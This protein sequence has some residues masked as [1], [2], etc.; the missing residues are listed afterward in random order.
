ML[1]KENG[2]TLRDIERDTGI[3]KSN[4]RF[5]IHSDAMPASKNLIK[6]CEYFNVSADWL[7]G[8]SNFRK[9]K[10]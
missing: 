6:L 10:R 9:V 3:G 1:Q 7:L 2:L 8:L 5:W 4:I